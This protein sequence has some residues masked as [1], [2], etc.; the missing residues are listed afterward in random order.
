LESELFADNPGTLHLASIGTLPR[1]LQARLVRTLKDATSRGGRPSVVRRVMASTDQDLPELI[2]SGSFSRELYEMLAVI[3]LKLPPLRERREDIPALVR[4]FVARFNEALSRTIKGVDESVFRRFQE[5]TW[6]GN[7]GELE[8][9]V[10][11]ACIVT[12][13]EMITVDDI[14]GSLSDSRFPGRQDVE[15]TL[16]RS[17]R[18]ALHERLVEA[19]AGAPSSVFH[20]LV[21]LVETTLVKEALAITNGNQVKASELLGVNRATLRKKATD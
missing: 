3:T 6:P 2:E 20:D 18:T 5:H 7:V 21:S 4:Y 8:S 10:K 19:A 16:N 11:R 17:V 14:A 9:V 12:R 15:S 13:S 1:P